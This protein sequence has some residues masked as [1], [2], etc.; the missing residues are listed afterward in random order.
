MKDAVR[1][2][3]YSA[4]ALFL[5][6]SGGITGIYALVVAFSAATGRHFQIANAGTSRGVPLPSTWPHA[7]LFTAVG[8]LLWFAGRRW[9][10][11][12]FAAVRVRRP[13][14]VPVVVVVVI[15]PAAL[16][17]LFLLVK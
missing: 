14:L 4:A 7:G 2:N 17:G 16:A 3:G 15:V 1:P 13:W 12:G 10:A 6:Y 9:D 5:L 8:V 11:P